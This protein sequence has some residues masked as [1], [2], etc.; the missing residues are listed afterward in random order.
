M[1]NH[2]VAYR[3]A[4]CYSNSTLLT[5]TVSKF[6]SNL[7]IFETI[8]SFSHSPQMLFL[9]KKEINKLPSYHSSYPTANSLILSVTNTSTLFGLHSNTQ[10]LLITITK[11]GEVRSSIPFLLTVDRR[12]TNQW[13]HKFSL[14]PSNQQKSANTKNEPRITPNKPY[15]IFTESPRSPH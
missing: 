6:C 13:Q 12:L 14:C 7:Q 11:Q 2:G 4:M 10:A 9:F 3:S 1:S 8:Y 15:H 5:I